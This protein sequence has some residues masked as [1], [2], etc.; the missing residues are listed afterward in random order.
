MKIIL[1]ILGS[2]VVCIVLLL[3]ILR[4]TGFE[5]RECASA[6]VAWS[7]RVP[8]LWLRGNVVTTPVTDW[9]FTDQYQTVKVQTRERFLAEFPLTLRTPHF[10][11]AR[12]TL[13]V[14]LILVAIALAG[15][16]RASRSMID[17]V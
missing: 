12:S 15:R 4:L 11:A 5:P 3:V 16:M 10:T 1:R 13:N 9:S 14:P 8:G 17:A 7:C 6:G 2:I